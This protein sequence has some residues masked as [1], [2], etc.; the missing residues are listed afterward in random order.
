MNLLS[1]TYILFRQDVLIGVGVGVGVGDGVVFIVRIGVGVV[2][3]VIVG[4]EVVLDWFKIVFL[5]TV[6]LVFVLI[7]VVG[8][9]WGNILL[10]SVVGLDS[11]KFVVI[12]FV[13]NSFSEYFFCV[14]SAISFFFFEVI[15]E[16][17]LVFSEESN[18]FL[19]VL[20]LFNVIANRPNWFVL[21]LYIAWVLL[22]STFK[23]GNLFHFPE[24]CCR[25]MF[26]LLSLIPLCS[27]AKWIF[28]K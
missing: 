20:V 21:D 12:F 4:I 23:V 13:D 5:D 2:V 19:M 25:T 6:A 11:G 3:G 26:W 22:E 24:K 16:L 15:E 14:D 28:D 1:L 10:G 27:T 17:R 9:T 18:G 8:I 7:C